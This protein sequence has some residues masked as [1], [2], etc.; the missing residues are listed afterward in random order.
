MAFDQVADEAATRARRLVDGADLDGAEVLCEVERFLSCFVCYP[1]A[2]AR[3]AHTL[4]IA[5][6][7]LMNQWDVTPRIAFLSP[8]PGSGKTRALEVTAPLVPRSIH[9]VNVSPAYLFRKVSDPAGLPTILFD[10]IDTVFG[11]KA[12]GNEDTRGMLNAGFRRGAFAGRAV[13][14]KNGGPVGIEELPAY[15]AVALAG[16]DDLPDTI[17]SRSILVRMRHRTPAEKIEPWRQRNGELIA[18][19]L[20]ERLASWTTAHSA[21]IDLASVQLPPE[22]TDRDADMWES[23]IAVADLAGGQWP[24]LARQ[25]AVEMILASK[26]RAP[27]VGVQ[28]LRDVRTVFS[29]YDF[30][31][32]SEVVRHLHDLP[33]SPWLDTGYGKPLTPQ[34]LAISLAKYEV[35]PI[36]DRILGETV[37][38]YRRRDLQ[39][40]WTRYLPEES[41]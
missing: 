15:A 8:E 12:H 30:L 9:A 17:M 38:G 5:H 29:D 21:L 22:V 33:D 16:L 10:E 3:V 2:S 34:K 23:L 18:Q 4:W 35:K 36:Q 37:R 26:D 31:A 41:T 32:S 7:W 11:P 25:S 13:A 40:A 20:A 28:L 14:S 39:D 24:S 6:T 1:T 27:T 19:P